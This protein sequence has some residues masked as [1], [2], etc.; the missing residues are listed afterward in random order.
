MA[1]G[2]PRAPSRVASNLND[3]ERER[4]V[5]ENLA[6]VSYIAKR[7]HS[8]IPEHIEIEDLMDSGVLGL[9]EAINHYDPNRQIK[10]MTFAKLRIEGAMLDSLRDLDWSPR[11]L[12][13]KGRQLED[14][15]HRLRSRMGR[16]PAQ[17]EVAAELGLTLE[18]L[19]QLLCELRGLDLG[20]L[21][22]VSAQSE[23][24]DQ[25]YPCVTSRD[26]DPLHQ[27][28]RSESRE[29]LARALDELPDRDRELIAL[30]YV[31]DLTMKEVGAVL[32]VGEGR[33]SQLHAAALNRLRRRLQEM[34]AP[35]QAANA[36]GEQVPE[37]TGVG[38]SMQPGQHRLKKWPFSRVS[39]DPLRAH[40]AARQHSTSA[41][42]QPQ[43]VPA[44]G[45]HN[46]R[47]RSS[48]FVSDAEK[49]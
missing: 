7:I 32:G 26:E 12:R 11:E 2:K 31:E 1:H 8:R 27:C 49:E 5:M 39:R 13:K 36:P 29:I 45:G 24:G 3:G 30:Y 46:A 15:L 42:Q 10:L 28:L 37:W 21:E 43:R 40:V 14:A 44:N 34:L 17:D 22:A 23:R 9:L 48:Y 47:K 19:D 16:A 41:P 18:S 25:P 4:L 20:S 38:A 35:R 33:I 6:E